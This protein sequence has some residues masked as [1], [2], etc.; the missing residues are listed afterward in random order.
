MSIELEEFKKRLNRIDE[1]VSS[2]KNLII[3]IS[4][5]DESAEPITINEDKVFRSSNTRSGGTETISRS[6]GMTR[7]DLERSAPEVFEI[8]VDQM[9]VS[10]EDIREI[11]RSAGKNAPVYRSGSSAIP[12]VNITYDVPGKTW[13]LLSDCRYKTNDGWE[14]LAPK[15]YE[16]DLASVPRFLWVFI[17]SFELGLSAPLFHD[18][19]YRCGGNLPDGQLNPLTDPRH[20]F[21]RKAA[22]DIFNE[23]M[24]KARVSWWKRNA[25]Y[26]AVRKFAGY[27]WQDD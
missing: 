7:D 10:D 2:G 13:I 18:L 12:T 20:R 3:N 9:D 26:Q 21:N 24:E 15:D 16:T 22:D 27:A 25:A 14:L 11:V 19:L 17:S 5:G 1:K 6:R 4:K 23:L 8:D